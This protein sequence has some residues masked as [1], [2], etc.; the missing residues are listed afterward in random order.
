MDEASTSVQDKE[1][2]KEACDL[3]GH[4]GALMHL[5]QFA[6]ELDECVQRIEQSLPDHDALREMAHQ[7]VFRAGILGFSDLADASMDLED[8]IRQKSG[9]ATAI[10]QWTRQ[11]RLAAA[12]SQDGIDRPASDA[13]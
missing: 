3:F 2:F 11:A 5:R 8:A 13:T 4:E 1:A 9:E 6:D 12:V 10:E 7:T